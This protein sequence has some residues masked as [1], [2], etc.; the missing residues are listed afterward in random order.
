[1]RTKSVES[2]VTAWPADV[3]DAYA[4]GGED[5][6]VIPRPIADDVQAAVAM[7]RVHQYRASISHRTVKR[8]VMT[9]LSTLA[10]DCDALATDI[11]SLA[12]SFLAQFEQRTAHLRIEIV[13]R[14]SCPKF[15]RDNV[16]VRLVT[17]YFG[18][19]TQFRHAGDDT[20]HSAPLYGL[21]FLKGHKH[22]I[23]GDLVYHR[24][25]EM[26]AGT[27][28]LCVVLDY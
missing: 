18:P 8:R 20:V 28:R 25:P 3:V 16:H 26:P 13:D 10:I 5:V 14:Q 7:G 2:G 22:N 19:A 6:L 1:M 23:D 11:I 15:H 27:K 4:E 9:G 24:S 21:V 12:R 17:T